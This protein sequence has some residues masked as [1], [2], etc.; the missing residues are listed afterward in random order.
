MEAILATAFGRMIDVQRGQ[1]SQLAE[2]AAAVFS[3]SHEDKKTSPR[4]VA[5]LLSMFYVAQNN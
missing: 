5:A 3:S 2:A 1:S 4:Y